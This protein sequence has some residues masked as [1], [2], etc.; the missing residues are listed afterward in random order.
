MFSHLTDMARDAEELKDASP[1]AP[2]PDKYPWGLRITLDQDSLEKLGVDH[3]DWEVGAVFHLMALAKVTSISSHDGPNGQRCDVGL[4][5][6]HLAGPEN[7][8][9]EEEEGEEDEE[10]DLSQHGYHRY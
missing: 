4:Q 7:E 9:K 1:M 3:S 8:E 6:T 5:I 10:P 2:E